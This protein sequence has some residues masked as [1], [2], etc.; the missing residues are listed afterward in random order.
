[1]CVY[2]CLRF[3]VCVCACVCVRARAWHAQHGALPC[4]RVRHNTNAGALDGLSARTCFAYGG[5]PHGVGCKQSVTVMLARR[6]RARSRQDL[7]W[8]SVRGHRHVC[9]QSAAITRTKPTSIVKHHNGGRSPW[10]SLLTK[11]AC[12]HAQAFVV[13]R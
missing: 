1:M 8:R 5:K 6:I 4:G 13:F 7:E 3:C 10:A 9:A 12:A 2:V 11:T